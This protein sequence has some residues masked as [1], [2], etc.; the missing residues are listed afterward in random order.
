MTCRVKDTTPLEGVYELLSEQG[1]AGMREAVE[2]L[3]NEVAKLERAAYLGAEPWERSEGR[4]GELRARAPVRAASAVAVISPMP[5]TSASR[6]ETAF[7]RC[8]AQSSTSSAA[9]SSTSAR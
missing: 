5:G 4:R 9:I 3:L 6:W 8:Q 2:K 7:V 1:F